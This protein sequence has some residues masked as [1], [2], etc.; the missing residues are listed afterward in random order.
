MREF[1]GNANVVFGDVNLQE[2]GNIPGKFGAGQGGW[3]TVRYFNAETGYDGAPYKQKTSKSMCDELGDMEY[4]RAYINEKGVPPCLVSQPDA[5]CSA[6]EQDYIKSW[7]AKDAAAVSAERAR[8][9]K[10]RDAKGLWARFVAALASLLTARRRQSR[11]HPMGEAAPRPSEAAG[12]QGAGS[13]NTQFLRSSEHYYSTLAITRAN[14]MKLRRET[15]DTCRLSGAAA[16]E[17]QSSSS[18]AA[19]NC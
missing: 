3:P 17:M 8:L 14:D 15:P 4:M 7:S 16:T 2:A 12:A 19:C 13:L 11:R 6:K 1:S 18:C 9:E 10:M 5:H